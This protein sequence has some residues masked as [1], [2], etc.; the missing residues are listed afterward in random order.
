MRM[1]QWW[2]DTDKGK[3]KYSKKNAVPV[4]LFPPR[5]SHGLNWDRSR[6]SER[7]SHGAAF[8]GKNY[9]KTKT[10]VNYIQRFSSYVAVN[11]LLPGYKVIG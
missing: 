6:A 3:P 7:L 8:N 2:N 4:P 5:I 11:M 10:I 9:L 1:M